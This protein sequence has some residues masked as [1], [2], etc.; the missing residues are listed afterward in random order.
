LAMEW[1]TNRLILPN[2]L[3]KRWNRTIYLRKLKGGLFHRLRTIGRQTT[4]DR[5]KPLGVG[6]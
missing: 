1:G 4:T 2:W 6:G 5:A 3:T